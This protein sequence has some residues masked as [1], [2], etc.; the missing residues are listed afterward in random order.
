MKM[1][2]LMT[3]AVLPSGG[4][5]EDRAAES[6]VVTDEEPTDLV[7]PRLVN[8]ALQI[9]ALNSS[10]HVFLRAN[11]NITSVLR[12]NMLPG[13][14]ES[15]VYQFHKVLASRA[16]NGTDL[17]G[18]KSVL[19]KYHPSMEAYQ[20]GAT[21]GCAQESFEH[22][23][24]DFMKE[25]GGDN[26]WGH[27]R[28]ETGEENN[29]ATCCGQPLQYEHKDEWPFVFM[30]AQN[31][32][33]GRTSL[34]SCV[35]RWEAKRSKKVRK[36]TCPTCSQEH[37]IQAVSMP[38]HMPTLFTFAFNPYSA[39]VSDV[40]EEISWAGV[41]YSTEGTIHHGD[42]HFWASSREHQ[43]EGDSWWMLEDY[44]GR[45]DTWRRQYVQGQRG[46]QTTGEGGRVMHKLEEKIVLLLLKRKGLVDT[47]ENQVEIIN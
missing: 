26:R 36:A 29:P 16:S 27:S 14:E 31:S 35:D 19:C 41:A 15:L 5:H 6:E 34:Q 38:E 9:C 39:T 13:I 28:K 33:S 47:E 20:P 24:R 43:E 17:L 21:G 44:C 8:G 12:R 2:M 40:A 22:L 42:G 10:F 25:V 37:A 46:L 3:M 11:P 30:I 1:A 23:V 32:A 7:T 4:A 45:V 18:V